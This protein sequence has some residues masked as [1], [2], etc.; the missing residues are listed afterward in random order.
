MNDNLILELVDLAISMAQQL[1]NG[2]TKDVLLQLVYRGTQAYEEHT[3]ETLNPSAI[4]VEDL[5]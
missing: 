3:G 4:E 1:D 5:L 2:T